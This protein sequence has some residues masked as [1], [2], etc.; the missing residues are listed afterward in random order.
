VVGDARF[1]PFADNS[2][3]TVFSYSVFQHF[4]KEN[5]KISL[6]EA[7]RVL[8]KNGKSLIQMPNN[9][10]SASINNIV[11]A[12]IQKARILKSVTGHRKN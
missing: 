9:T 11:D 7:A 3:N 4:S 6:D 1:L 5:T 10:A 2:F 8:K 12:D